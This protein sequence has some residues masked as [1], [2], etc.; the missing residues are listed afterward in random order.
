M[1]NITQ[2]IKAYKEIQIQYDSLESKVFAT[3]V[4]GGQKY[5]IC[6]SIKRQSYFYCPHCKTEDFDLIKE[7][8]M[9]GEPEIKTIAC[10]YGF[11]DTR[12]GKSYVPIL[13][14]NKSRNYPVSVKFYCENC[15]NE[16][17]KPEL[18]KAL[19]ERD[20]QYENEKRN[21]WQEVY[22]KMSSFNPPEITLTSNK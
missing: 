7:R 13:D 17:T 22:D 5:G 10:G 18:L 21:T 2:E 1:N 14:G 12:Y 3:R 6:Q 4:I 11:A 8:K 9:D 19:N 16:H 15:R 20:R